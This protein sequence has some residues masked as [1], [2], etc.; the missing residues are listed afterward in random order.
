[1]LNVSSKNVPDLES[2][3]QSQSIPKFIAFGNALLDYSVITKNDLIHQRHELDLN[4]EGECSSLKILN[5]LNDMKELLAE[6]FNF[7]SEN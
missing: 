2:Q 5:I 7:L 4:Q 6:K 3:S 1:M